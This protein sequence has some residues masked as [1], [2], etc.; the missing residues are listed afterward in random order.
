MMLTLKTDNQEGRSHGMQGNP[1]QPITLRVPFLRQ[2]MG[3]GDVVSQVTQ[4][5][6]IAPCQ[7]CK[8]RQEAMNQRVRLFPW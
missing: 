4:A 3:L 7:P 1:S 2:Q 8:K 6:R 5:V